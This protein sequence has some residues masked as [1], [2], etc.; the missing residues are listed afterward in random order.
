MQP[1]AVV[2]PDRPP[3][4][5]AR[6]CTT[7]SRTSA[8]RCRTSSRCRS[9]S[10]T[11]ATTPHGVGKI[12]HPGYDDEPSWTRAVGGDEGP[13][14]RPRRPEAARGARR[15]ARGRA[16]QDAAKVRGPAV[17]G[18]RRARTTTSTTA[19]PRTGRSRCSRRARGKEEPFFL[20]VGFAKPHL[21]FVAPKKYWDLYDPAKLPV[22]ES[23]DPPKDAPKFAPQFGGE[24]RRY[25]DI[26]KSGP[27]PKEHGPQ[28]RS[29][30]L[31]RRQLHG[32]A[33]RPR[34]RGAGANRASPTTR[35]SILW[36][37]HGW[38]LG[39]HGMWCKHTNYEQATRARARG[40]R[41]GPEGRRA[42]LRRARRVRGHLPD[43]RGT[44]RAAEPKGVEGHSFAPLLHDPKKPWK[45]AAFS[46]YPRG[47]KDTGP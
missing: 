23:A 1:V 6:R 14:L 26:P 45:A 28:A 15:Q 42:S 8:R 7:S 16:R 31:R 13:R 37:D 38:H 4:G 34:A 5:H 33:G 2:A 43:A 25:H 47:G 29:R 36:G 30:L 32:R 46:Q 44:V 39:D 40:Q 18:A 41:A 35:W 10:R 24:L 19:G 20:A 9:T 27:M 11:T 3:A 17:R 12:Y 21:P 22:A